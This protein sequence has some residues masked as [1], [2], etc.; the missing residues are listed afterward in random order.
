M[1]TK[2]TRNDCVKKAYIR[3]VFNPIKETVNMKTYSN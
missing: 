1:L 2:G 3:F